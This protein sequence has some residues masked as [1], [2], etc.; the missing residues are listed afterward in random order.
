MARVR[1]ALV[2][3]ILAAAPLGAQE[4]S[5]AASTSTAASSAMLLTAPSSAVAPVSAS[6][7]TTGPTFDAARSG[8]HA[9]ASTAPLAPGATRIGLGQARAM[10]I[11]GGAALLAGAIIGG[12]AGA[13][14]MVGGAVVGLVGLYEYL[15]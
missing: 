5:S 14:I 8:F 2:A 12:D 6:V 7:A 3:L 11:V 13:I 1:L 10:M 9:P 4:I 15:Q